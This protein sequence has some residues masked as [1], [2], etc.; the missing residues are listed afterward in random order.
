[1]SAGPPDKLRLASRGQGEGSGAVEPEPPCSK[2]LLEFL[3]A[4]KEMNV[5][6]PQLLEEI[7]LRPGP[8][9]VPLP[10]READSEA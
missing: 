1:M 8:I 2:G 10:L 6:Y 9:D 3:S 7:E 5:R 4:A